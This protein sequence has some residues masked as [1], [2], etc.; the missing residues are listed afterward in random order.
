MAHAVAEALSEGQHLIVQAGTGTGKT[1]AYL[2]PVIV[3]GKKTIVTTATKA[4]QDQLAK[5]DLPFLVEQLN[6]RRSAGL[7]EKDHSLRL[8]GKVRDR[9]GDLF[10]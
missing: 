1:I 9:V 6:L 3:A 10:L 5:K 8:R 4:L 2:V 7:C